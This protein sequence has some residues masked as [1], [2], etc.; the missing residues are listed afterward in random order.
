MTERGAPLPLMRTQYFHD[1]GI[2]Y[3]LLSTREALPFPAI[4]YR[5]WFIAFALDNHGSENPPIYCI[6]H[7]FLGDLAI[8]SNAQV[9]IINYNVVIRLHAFR[10]AVKKTILAREFS[11]SRRNPHSNKSMR[12]AC[13]AATP[14]IHSYRRDGAPADPL[15]NCRIRYWAEGRAFALPCPE[16]P[17]S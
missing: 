15:R 13:F 8:L 4:P 10:H 12:C 1:A 16:L 3:N 17:L 7:R 6:G 11:I 9:I 5:P 14:S 2:I